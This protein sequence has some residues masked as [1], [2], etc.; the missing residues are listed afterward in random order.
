MRVPFAALDG[1][2]DKAA[3]ALYEAAQRGHFISKDEFQSEAGVSKSVI[4]ALNQMGVL[5]ALP[6]SNQMT[7]F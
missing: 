6:D 7:L 5:D 3:V 1:V 2:G 4:E